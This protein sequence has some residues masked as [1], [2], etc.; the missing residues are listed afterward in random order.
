MYC[1]NCGVKLADTEKKCPLCGVAA[2]HPEQ[3]PGQ[4]EPLYPADRYPAAQVSPKG[5]QIIVTTLFLLPALITLLCDLQISGTVTW[6]GFVIGALAVAYVML[7]L[8]FWF[9][10]RNPVVFIP[11]SFAAVGLYVMYINLALDGDWF[12]SFAFPVV[13]VV[14]I[15]VTAVVTLLRYIRR[16]R[17]YVFGGALIALGLFMPLMEFLSVVTFESVRFAGWSFYPMIVLTLFGGM[18]LFLAGNGKARERMER[19]FFI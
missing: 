19:K 10:R 3:I 4:G 6:S 15:I 12:L 7:V 17:L 16:G 18:F 14:G 1:V 2:W 5:A 11:V 8:P 13:G 9:R